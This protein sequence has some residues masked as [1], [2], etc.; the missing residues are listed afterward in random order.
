MK[1]M[2]R[3]KKI[4]KLCF[5]LAFLSI[6]VLGCSSEDFLKES[7]TNFPAPEILLTNKKGAEIYTVGSY[8]AARVLASDFDGWL[9]MWGTLGADEIVVPN[10]GVDSKAIFLHTLSPSTATIRT[11]WENLY[12]STNRVSSAVDRISA[13]TEDQIDTD[14]KNKL[15]GESR[16]IRAML[17]FALVTTW[18][19]VPL[20]KNETTSLENLE[21]SQA[22]PKEV[23]EFIIDDLLYAESVLDEGQGGGRAT[24][25]AAQAFLGKVYLQMTGFPLNETDKYA[26][27][28][29][30]LKEVIDSGVYQLL[31]FYPDV[32]DLSNEQNN[33]MVF[34]IGFDGPGLNQGG[35]LGTFYGPNGQPENGGQGGNN[36]FV[37]WE[38]A[39]T[40]DNLPVGSG[41]WAAR[42][43]YKFAQGYHEDDIRCRNN[44]AKHNVN[45]GPWTPEDG[46]YNPAAR[47]VTQ[48]GRRPTWK[49][50]KWHNIR[51]S[52]WGNDTPFDQ[53][54]IRYADVLLM[55]AEALNGQNKLTQND[56]DVTVNLL[57]ERATRFPD[58]VK[59]QEVAPLMVLSSQ[60]DNA[61]E[62]LSER[63][64][65]L[66]FEG[67]RRND[68]I[69]FGK[70]KEAINVTQPSWSTT[71]NPQPQYSDFE[72]RWPIPASE[73][74]INSNLDQNPMYN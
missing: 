62:I 74:L 5:S 8:N 57:R 39:G 56:I 61:D 17:Y 24:K 21:V 6:L 23:Y 63:R 49:P 35:S 64:K 70:Y 60:Q 20:I 44:I 27:A 48:P 46:M 36:W 18:E 67:W 3:L 52:N 13:M 22:T 38:L 55:Y 29:A 4:I 59:P 12:R 33:E 69:R 65:E 47:I 31:D 45:Q 58:E 34:A 73:I 9:S 32:F 28:E 51:P 10:W 25:G 40:S 37:N 54:V 68:L 15:V 72:I 16:F 1:K 50:W 19:N 11:M 53:P 43:N 14:S 26:L 42:S 71:G 66:C 7:P 2:K 30:K 41:S